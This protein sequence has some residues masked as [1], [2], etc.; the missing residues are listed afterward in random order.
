[1][2]EALP[3]PRNRRSG[4][5][6]GQAG[7]TARP[8]GLDPD[9]TS[10]FRVFGVR[11]TQPRAATTGSAPVVAYSVGEVARLSGLSVRTLHHFDQIGV[12][13]P[14][15]R[16]EN[17]YRRYSQADLRRLQR[18]LVY[19]ELGFPLKEISAL[20]SASTP[21]AGLERQHCG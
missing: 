17:G 19:R 10:G 14:G 6:T 2:L 3:G 18:L 4:G 21:K 11:E 9:V 12:L 13:K 1:M 8:G 20:L 7:V 16:G 15:E 5:A